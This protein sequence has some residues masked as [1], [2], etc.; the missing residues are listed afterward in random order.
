MWH[1]L[2]NKLSLRSK[3]RLCES[4]VLE[5]IQ[6]RDRYLGHSVCVWYLEPFDWTSLE[7]SLIERKEADRISLDVCR[8]V[9]K[10]P[11]SE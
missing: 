10:R 7:K 4:L 11:S 2:L 8:R 1:L 9:R 6:A 3:S 5:D